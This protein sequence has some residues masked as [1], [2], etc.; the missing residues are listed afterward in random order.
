LTADAEPRMLPRPDAPIG[1]NACPP[2]CPDNPQTTTL[3]T[4]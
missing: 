4:A 1:A 3:R 2:R